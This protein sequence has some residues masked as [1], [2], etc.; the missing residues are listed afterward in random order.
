MIN[1]TVDKTPNP[2]GV[3]F[4]SGGLLLLPTSTENKPR[5]ASVSCWWDLLEELLES[6]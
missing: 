5:R 1:F 4:F 3:S 2:F 6:F